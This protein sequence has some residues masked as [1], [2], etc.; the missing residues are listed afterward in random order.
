M[1]QSDRESRTR[2]IK[3]TA[4]FGV[5]A[6]LCVIGI[7]LPRPTESEIEKR[8]LT[9]FPAFTWESFWSGK[10]FSGI[11]TWYADTY[12]L[13][14]LLIGGNKV[15]QSLYGIRSDVIVGGENQGEEIP[16]IEG[17]QG[18]LPTL[19]KD[20]PENKTDDPQQDNNTEP[21]RD[22]NVSADGEMISGIFVSGNVGYGLYYFQQEN[23]DWYAAILNEMDKRL[24]GKAQLY[25]LVAPINGGV[26]L[27]D[28]LQK[29]LHISD[30]REAIRYIYSRMAAD[31]NGVEVF[32]ALR[33]HVDEYIYFHTD[34][35]WTALGAYYAYTQ[36]A[37]AAGLTPHMLDQFEQVEFPNFLGTYYS[38]SGI[39][40]LGA[41]PDTVI[42]YKPMGT[43]KMKMTMADGTTYD[44]FV[45][46]DV[47]G[48][49]SSMKYGAFAGGDQ[50]YSV[51]ENPEI[52]DGSAC[53]VIKDS[54]G[55][56]L[57]P[58]LVDHY[59]YLYWIDFRYYKGSIYD[60]VAE[61]N[62]K[63]VLVLQQIYNTGDSG[64]LKKLQALVER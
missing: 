17:G 38:V 31:I 55:N 59:Q 3:L 7:F 8:K 25:S 42:A 14:E 47:S 26:L 21:P 51:V 9:E 49:G 61:K 62:I 34:H 40:S 53:L 20:D 43:N 2:W 19:P 37:K 39:T 13:R 60:L 16:D 63:D 1:K 58:Y 6:V 54:Y 27:R 45:V 18:E 4:F 10:W 11:D 41:N 32:D 33:E 30:Q 12:P 15:V 23:S 22:G 52:T 64:A 57:I 48:Y 46:N 36:Y 5:L 29:E 44:W 50:P 35:H 56:A 28:S 24:A